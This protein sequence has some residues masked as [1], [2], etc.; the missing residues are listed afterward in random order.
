[1]SVVKGLDCNSMTRNEQETLE[2]YARLMRFDWRQARR[3]ARRVFWI[4]TSIWAFASVFGFIVI[5]RWSPSSHREAPLLNGPPQLVVI[6]VVVALSLY[7]R[8][9]S[10]DAAKLRDSI[11]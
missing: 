4:V 6:S 8:N 1:M 9:L 5:S 10:N 3:R 2:R 7:L 11:R